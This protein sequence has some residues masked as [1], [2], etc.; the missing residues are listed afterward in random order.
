MPA[1]FR[2]RLPAALHRLM[3]GAALSSMLLL[4]ACGGGG[5]TTIVVAPPAPPAPTP[6]EI[7]GVAA[8]MQ[9]RWQDSTGQT[10]A[11]VLPITSKGQ[12]PTWMVN[13]G[14]LEVTR[15]DLVGSTGNT[16][17]ATGKRYGLNIAAGQTQTVTPIDWSGT[18]SITATAGNLQFTGGPSLDRKD[19]LDAA[20]VQLDAVGSWRAT[21]GNGLVLTNVSIDIA[22]NLSGNSSTGCVYSG[23]LGAR[24]DAAVYDVSLVEI[25]C[26]ANRIFS[27]VGSLSPQK[28]RLT[29]VVTLTDGSQAALMAFVRQ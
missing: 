23:R 16:V 2:T 28:D 11:L 21:R 7:A 1:R 22:G 4:T 27:G 10:T 19:K 24:S 6:T 18:V 5:T 17:K 29:L 15:L 3:A 12:A 8:D 20:S 25:G 9:G 14:T 13:E 26:D